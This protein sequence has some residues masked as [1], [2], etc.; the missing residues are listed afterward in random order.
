MKNENI[1]NALLT[2]YLI[3]RIVEAKNGDLSEKKTKKM[4]KIKAGE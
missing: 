3:S 4:H 2:I 1:K